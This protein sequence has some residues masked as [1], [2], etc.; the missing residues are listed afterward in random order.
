Q[1]REREGAQHEQDLGR[2][3]QAAAIEAVDN[4]TGEQTDQQDWGELSERY[5]AEHR[6]RVRQLQ[7]QPRLGGALHP[8]AGQRGELAEE[9][10]TIVAMA[11]RAKRSAAPAGPF[12]RRL[13]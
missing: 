4:Y 10:E 2:D 3:Y 9:I 11:K 13:E 8:G 12:A 5:N 1:Y 7:H 6:G